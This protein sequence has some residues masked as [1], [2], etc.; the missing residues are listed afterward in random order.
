M[1]TVF[2]QKGTSF[3]VSDN[4]NL[5]VVPTLPAKNFIVQYDGQID[6]LYLEE[7]DG[8]DL[9]SK[10]YGN[11]E[12]Q[13]NRIMSTFLER[14][15]STGVLLAGEKGSG[16]TLLAK[17]LSATA[18][19]QGYPTIIV[20]QQWK[21]DKFNKLIQDVNQPCVV[22]FDEFEKVYD[23]EGQEQLL[24][25]LD[26][27]FPSKKLFVLTCNNMYRVDQHMMNRPGRL[28]YAIEF[29]GLTAEFVQEYCMLNLKNTEWASQVGQVVTMFENFNFDMLKALVEEMNRYDESPRAALEMLN[30][31]PRSDSGGTWNVELA[32]KGKPVVPSSKTWR[33]NPLSTNGSIE[34]WLGEEN[35]TDVNRMI[36]EIM[37]VELEEDDDRCMVF[38]QT[39]LKRI[40]PNAGTLV[41]TNRFDATVTFT[42]RRL[43]S[44][45]Y[46]DA[47]F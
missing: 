42:R 38:E 16:K 2:R 30:I 40:E 24:T 31:K 46:R 44:F 45:D 12:R 13:A 18:A 34:I 7:V 6:E 10:L 8:F 9:P 4:A 35:A 3:Y 47:L 39:D 20:N 25:L 5:V 27:V 36:D 11:T 14:T 17:I 21:G 28:F 26:G 43:E 33:G 29:K 19:E 22:F 1:A 23:N 32:V 37:G 41:Y 15:A